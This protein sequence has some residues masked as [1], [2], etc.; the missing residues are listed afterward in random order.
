MWRSLST[1]PHLPFDVLT[2]EL[3]TEGRILSENPECKKTEFC[4]MRDPR[5][6][7]RM[8]KQVGCQREEGC[9]WCLLVAFLRRQVDE[10]IGEE[11]VG[12]SEIVGSKQNRRL[13]SRAGDIS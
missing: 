5:R 10:M 13:L 2:A 7:I 6:A 1:K 9:E 4:V 8:V 11:F 12:I 3:L